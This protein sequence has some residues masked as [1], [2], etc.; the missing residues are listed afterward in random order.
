MKVEVE[1]CLEAPVSK[2]EEELKGQLLH[3]V[4]RSLGKQIEAIITVD[5][6]LTKVEWLIKKRAWPIRPS[7]GQ[8][9][10]YNT[11]GARLVADRIYSQAITYEEHYIPLTAQLVA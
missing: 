6:S 4:Y 11:R 1:Q 2:E 9:I 10:R 7:Y 8:A 5:K 3:H